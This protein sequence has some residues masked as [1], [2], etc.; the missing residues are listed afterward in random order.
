M[1]ARKYETFTYLY[2]VDVKD[3]QEQKYMKYTIISNENAI[4][5]INLTDI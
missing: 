1:V 3:I 4:D 2:R 5:V